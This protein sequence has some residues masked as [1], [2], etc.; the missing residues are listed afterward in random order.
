M[1]K[2]STPAGKPLNLA[3]FNP[4]ASPAPAAGPAENEGETLFIRRTT[5]AAV[6]SKFKPEEQ[7]NHEF[8]LPLK[9][10][11]GVI[12]YCY[13]RGVFTS[14]EIATRLLQEPELRRTVGRDLP[15]EAAIRR[16]RRKYAGEIEEALETLYQVFPPQDPAL[17]SEA[18]DASGDLAHKLAGTRV[19]DAIWKD[20]GLPGYPPADH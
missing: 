18:V 3:K 6:E 12:T 4:A 10:M 16:F 15:D 8:G 7:Q 2:S 11:L 13:A 17:A 14:A 1:N 5:A 20:N 19:H 9:E